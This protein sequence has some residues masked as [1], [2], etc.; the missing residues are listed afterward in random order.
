MCFADGSVMAI[1]GWAYFACKWLS[2]TASGGF[3]LESA[4]VVW[5]GTTWEEGAG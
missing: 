1:E 3:G 4:D 5:L 2:E